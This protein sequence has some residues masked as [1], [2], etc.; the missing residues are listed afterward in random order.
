MWILWAVGTIALISF[1]CKVTS[2]KPIKTTPKKIDSYTPHLI[3]LDGTI[4]CKKD[5]D[6]RV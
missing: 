2:P 4:V 3:N 1:V 5:I 6:V